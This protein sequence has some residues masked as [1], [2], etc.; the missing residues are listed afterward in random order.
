MWEHD[1]GVLPVVDDKDRVRGV[2]TDRDICMSAYTRGH[3]L[4]DLRVA[5]S[6]SPTVVSCQPDDDVAVAAQRMAEHAVRRLPV[7]DD[8]GRIQG[9]VSLNDLARAGARDR[10][11][12][13]A[14]SSVLELVCRPRPAAERARPA[15]V[16][17]DTATCAVPQPPA[18]T[19]SSVLLASKID[20]EC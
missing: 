19:R 4:S 16:R 9:I 6:M 3:R 1:C 14:A 5:N 7:V 10:D 11:V 20:N 12:A 15:A 2:I 13:K 17:Q 8:K 18:T